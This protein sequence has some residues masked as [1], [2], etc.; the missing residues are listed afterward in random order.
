MKHDGYGPFSAGSALLDLL[1]LRMGCAYLSDLR[2]LGGARREKLAGE[3]ERLPAREEDLREW[4]DALAYLTEAPPE[5]TARAAK[6]R[7]IFLLT[8]S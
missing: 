4:N 6:E 5:P 2:Y 8:H 1:S 7:L 3:V